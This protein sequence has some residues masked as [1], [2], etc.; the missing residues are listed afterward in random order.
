MK[1]NEKADENTDSNNP[2]PA[3]QPVVKQ[4]PR[5]GALGMF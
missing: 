1:K 5:L 4:N 3:P 2:N